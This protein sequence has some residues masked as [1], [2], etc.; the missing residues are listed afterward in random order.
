MNKEHALLVNHLMIHRYNEYIYLRKISISLL[1][2]RRSLIKVK[3]IFFNPEHQLSCKQVYK[4]IH[5]QYV[6]Y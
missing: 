2:N 4:I 5:M 3:K 1:E 6:K